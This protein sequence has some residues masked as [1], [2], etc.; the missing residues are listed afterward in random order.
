MTLEVTLDS[1]GS[2]AGPPRILRPEGGRPDEARLVA[3]A[4][5][6]AAI[7]A[8]LPYRAVGGAGFGRAYRLGFGG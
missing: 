5:A 2:L 4:Q 8:C 7:Q 1:K 3:E 6:L